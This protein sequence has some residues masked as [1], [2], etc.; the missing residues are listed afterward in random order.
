MGAQ[1]NTIRLRQVVI[2]HFFYVTT[3]AQSLFPLF[4]IC[5]YLSNLYPPYNISV[6]RM[7]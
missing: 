6:L 5:I 3:V 4:G 1:T 2:L 7:L